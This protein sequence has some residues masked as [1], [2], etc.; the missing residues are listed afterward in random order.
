MPNA[1]QKQSKAPRTTTVVVLKEKELVVSFFEKKFPFSE[2][3]SAPPKKYSFLV[4]NIP[5]SLAY[6]I[7]QQTRF[8]LSLSLD[9]IN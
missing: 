5:L 7:P 2:I 9:A 4:W 8:S 6:T 1:V 3:S